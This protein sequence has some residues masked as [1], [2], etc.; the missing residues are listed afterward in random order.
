MKL[1]KGIIIKRQE[2]TSNTLYKV[3]W[4]GTVKGIVIVERLDNND[5][6]SKSMGMVNSN[7]IVVDASKLQKENT[8]TQETNVSGTV[9]T[10]TINFETKQSYDF[11]IKAEG[12]I[13][14]KEIVDSLTR[15]FPMATVG[16]FDSETN[17]PDHDGQRCVVVH[18]RLILKAEALGIYP[19]S[20][21]RNNVA[22][23]DT[24]FNLWWKWANEV[25]EANFNDGYNKKVVVS[26]RKLKA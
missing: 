26:M 25:N 7:Y 15:D 5:V 20:P 12:T 11:P 3:L 10:Q 6:M 23:T 4:Y 17:K 2:E 8:M 24:D 1:S 22:Y 13:N 21:I 18:N 14:M 16:M 9:E 19:P